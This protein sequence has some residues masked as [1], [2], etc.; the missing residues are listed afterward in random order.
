[1]K[2]KDIMVPCTRTLSPA[3]TV[4]DA[5]EAFRASKLTGVPV[6]GA[7]GVLSGI[8]TRFNLYECLLA[9]AGLD[10]RIE[11]YY[12]REVISLP[13][14]QAFHSPAELD[15]WLRHARIGQTPLV[16]GRGRPIG[17]LTQAQA[18]LYLLDHIELLY[19]ELSNILQQAPCGILATDGQGVVHLVSTHLQRIL[20]AVRVGEQIGDLL[21]GL[22]FAEIV[23]GSRLGPRKFRHRSQVLL[24]NGLP[25]MRDGEVKSVILI[26]Q[27]AS[28]IDAVVRRLREEDRPERSPGDAVGAE[29]LY[30]LNGTKYTIDSIVGTSP[31]MEEIKRKVL[32]IAR[33]PSTVLVTGESGTGKEI[34]AQAVHNASDRFQRPFV[35]VNCAAIPLELAESELFG[36]EGGGFT[37]ALRHGKPGKF[38]I[39]DGGTL[40]LDEIGDMPLPM[41]GKLLRVIQEREVERVG[42]V[43][44]KQ[45]D[46][47]IIAA[48]NKDLYRLAREDKFRRDL[49]YRLEVLVLNVPPL[50]DHREDVPALAAY[51]VDKFAKTLGKGVHRVDPEVGAFLAA[52][53]WPGNVRELENVLHRAVIYARTATVE[54][55]D[56]G[57]DFRGGGSVGEGGPALADIAREAVLRALEASGG[58]KSRAA[59][60]LGISR[61]TLYEKLRHIK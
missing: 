7:G 38:E 22:P 21:P 42:G 43:K 15:R 56:L 3:S 54:M 32:Q 39:A 44:T 33:T 55:D 50:R 29:D 47:R 40:F 20:P 52:Y 23:D 1:M 34:I 26:L 51:F 30:Q 49:L 11:P 37:G 18:V 59:R 57:I 48:T 2:A 46:V 27:D 16:D 58:N 24:V 31:A 28:E 36:Y 4:R 13:E 8:F 45:V 5:L 25:V 10:D 14:D 53:S 9:G 19:E 60:M 61:A 17:M 35:K 6:A 41:Q 12:L